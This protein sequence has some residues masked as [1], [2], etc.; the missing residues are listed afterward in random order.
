MDKETDK[1]TIDKEKVEAR[2]S[3]ASNDKYRHERKTQDSSERI[4]KEGQEKMTKIIS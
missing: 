4:T 1:L 2:I 3:I